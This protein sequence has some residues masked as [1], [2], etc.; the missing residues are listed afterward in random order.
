MNFGSFFLLFEKFFTLMWKYLQHIHDH[1][2]SDKMEKLR[3]HYEAKVDF[4]P[5]DLLIKKYVLPD[6]YGNW[7]AEELMARIIEFSI[8]ENNWVAVSASNL[9]KSM[10]KAFIERSFP[11]TIP[12]IPTVLSTEF[13][14]EGYNFL[15]ANKLLDVMELRDDLYFKPAEKAILALK[16][17]VVKND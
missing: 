1:K 16:K 3:I 12:A 5:S 11:H 4:Q 6:T 13:M 2:K 17:F 14:L 9:A 8:E 15:F 10:W 7:A